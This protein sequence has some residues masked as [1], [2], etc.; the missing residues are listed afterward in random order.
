MPHEP[1]YQML[2]IVGTSSLS[3]DDAI[4]NGPEKAAQARHPVDWFQVVETRGQVRG[5]KVTQFQVIMKV[6]MRLDQP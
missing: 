3:S 6:G 1:A 5:G 4:R 2:E